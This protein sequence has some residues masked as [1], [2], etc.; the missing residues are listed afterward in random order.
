MILLIAFLVVGI[1]VY[2]SSID[3]RRT[4][5]TVFFL[6]VLEGALRKWVLPQASNFIYFLKDFVLLGAYIRYYLLSISER[7]VTIQ[8]DW[9]KLLIFMVSAWCFFQ[10]FN[11]SLGSPIVG[12]FGLRG[13]LFYIPL[14]WMLPSLFQSEEELYKFLRTHLLLAIPIGILGIAQFFS[15]A[16]SILNVYSNDEGPAVATFGVSTA[17]RIT[18]S[19]SYISGYA[20]YLL[21]CFGLLIPFLSINQ[22]RW[23]RWA[24]ITEIFLVTVNSFMTGSRGAVFANVLLFVGYLSVRALIQ[25]SNTL[26]LIQKFLIPALIVAIA[27]SIWFKPAIDAFWLRTTSNKDVSGRI[28]GSFTEPLDFIKYKQF[29]GYGTGATHQAAPALRKALNLSQAEP[30]PVYFE[31]EMGRVSL[32]LGPFGFLL[33]YGLRISIMIALWF[34]FWRL[35]RPFLQQLALVAFL[36]HALQFNGQLVV[37]HTFSVYYWFLSSFIWV[38][39]RLEQIEIWRYKQ[40]KV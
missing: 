7:K 39:P 2:I 3:W 24:S 27:A 9:I 31:S 12:F 15:P 20:V 11:P 13:Y 19:F 23:W 33:W 32:E 38:L 30:I 29:D 26:R 37:H 22:S 18:G 1:I 28:S 4:I 25:P 8:S 34:V 36:T 17:V 21:V 16:N 10:A 35:K 14:M 40:E 6:L 5:Q